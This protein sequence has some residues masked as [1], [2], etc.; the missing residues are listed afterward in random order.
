MIYDDGDYNSK[1][2]CGGEG[3]TVFSCKRV[4]SGNVSLKS[5]CSKS[6]NEAFLL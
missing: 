1:G 2:D 3:G 6:N 4:M 5:K